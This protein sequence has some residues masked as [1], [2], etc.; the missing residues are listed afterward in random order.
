LSID[1]FYNNKAQS[2]GKTSFC[3]ICSKLYHRKYRKNKRREYTNYNIKSKYGMTI[4]EYDVLLKEQNNKCYICEKENKSK[5][6]LA[7]DHCHK[8]G[9][10]R[11]LL[12]L[13]CNTA[14]GKLEPFMNKILN[15]IRYE[16]E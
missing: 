11:G 3:K 12:C 14:L 8:T 2:S 9:R 6:R 7:I 1:N 10:I 16:N 15:Y 4:E 5:K 13:Q